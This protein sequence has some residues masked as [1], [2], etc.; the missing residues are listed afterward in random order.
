MRNVIY[1]RAEQWLSEPPASN[2]R[3]SKENKYNKNNSNNNVK[4][5]TGALTLHK[6]SRSA[7]NNSRNKKR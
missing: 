5:H 3:K 6:R 4:S 2:E 7:N 1:L